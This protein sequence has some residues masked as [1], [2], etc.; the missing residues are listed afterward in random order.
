MHS[1]GS[2]RRS[3]E[4]RGQSRACGRKRKQTQC[5]LGGNAEHSF[6]ADK[7]TD[8]VEAGFILVHASARPQDIAVG[9]HDFDHP[10]QLL[11][12]EKIAIVLQDPVLFAGTIADNVRLAHPGLI[13]GL[14]DPEK[15]IREA[16]SSRTPR[17]RALPI[18]PLPHCT[19]GTRGA[20]G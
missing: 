4:R 1:F 11:A 16:E 18:A 6:R 15:L 2:L 19:P 12:R 9:Q 8:Q 13:E 20:N 17:Q 3:G 7:K 10:L 14:I 5:D